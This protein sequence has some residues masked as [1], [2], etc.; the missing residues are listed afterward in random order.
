MSLNPIQIMKHEAE[1]ERSETARLSSFVGA[2]AI[3]DL[4]KST[5]G[6]RGMD[7]ILV[8]MGRS[9]GN[10]NAQFY[11][12]CNSFFYIYLCFSDFDVQNL[13]NRTKQ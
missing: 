9:E 3:G 8:S 4:I 10:C 5:L 2:I 1:E 13:C 11:L 6:P 7:K 12:F